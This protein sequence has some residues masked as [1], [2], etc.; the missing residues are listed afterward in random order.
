MNR[1]G[2]SLRLAACCQ[3][4]LNGNAG[5]RNHKLIERHISYVS[6]SAGHESSVEA[7]IAAEPVKRRHPE[8]A[9]NSTGVADR[10]VYAKE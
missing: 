1:A 8:R 10:G 9:H 6:S 4:F 5:Q 3:R 7:N 2:D